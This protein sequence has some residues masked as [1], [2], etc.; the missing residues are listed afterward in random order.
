MSSLYDNCMKRIVLFDQHLHCC[1][2][3]LFACQIAQQIYVGSNSL[4]HL[5]D[6]DRIFLCV[7]LVALYHH[8][9]QLFQPLKVQ[10]S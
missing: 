4:L 1:E 8:A 5:F 7:I 10:F 3:F 9:T 6:R 2:H